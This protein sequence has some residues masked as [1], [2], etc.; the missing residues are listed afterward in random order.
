MEA[1]DLLADLYRAYHDARKHKRNTINQLRFEMDLEHHLFDLCEQLTQRTYAPLPSVAFIVSKPVQREIF[2]ADF[3]DRVIHHLFFNYVNP[4]F[5]HTY[6]DDSYSC[7]KGKGTHYGV[8]RLDHHIRS[9]SDNYTRPCFVM[10]LDLE[11]YFMS[12][13]RSI[14]YRQVESTLLRYAN[15]KN[16]EGVK[17]K[18]LLDYDLVLYL[19]QVIIFNDPAKNYRIKGTESDWQGLPLSKSLFHS[20][21]GK[22]LPIG[23][24][25]SQ[26]FSNIFLT[27]FDNYV[28]RE[29]KFKH[30]GRYVDD[31]YL[32]HTDKKVLKAAIPKIKSFLS[33]LL[34]LKLHPRKIYLQS[35]SNGVLFTG[36]Y[37]KPHR[38]YTSNRTKKSFN[39]AL[40][41]LQTAHR[42]DFHLDRDSL[43]DSVNSYLGIMKHY[44]SFHVRRQ[45]LKKN[46][47][48]FKYGFVKCCCSCYKYAS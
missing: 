31:F 15:R 27:P 24:L 45:I 25:T 6:I 37:L 43:R 8:Q 14:L 11:G 9:C 47:W 12:I 18:N 13:D 29:L 4:I 3:R 42:P 44:Q 33:S 16:S 7:R 36:A 20:P 46:T 28:K 2:A 19:A 22:G 5:E 39:A 40:K 21:E 38:I 30:Y 34:N 23:N 10:K 32:V 48:I 41:V 1:N 17:W 35:H 26:M